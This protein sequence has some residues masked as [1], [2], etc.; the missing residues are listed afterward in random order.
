MMWSSIFTKKRFLPVQKADNRS[1]SSWGVAKKFPKKLTVFARSL[2]KIV[3][4]DDAGFF[5]EVMAA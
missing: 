5:S 4:A 1:A 2:W 3:V